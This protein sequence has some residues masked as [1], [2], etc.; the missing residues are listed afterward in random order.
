M[1]EQEALNL[2]GDVIARMGGQGDLREVAIDVL[3]IEQSYQRDIVSDHADKIARNWNPLALGVLIASLRADGKLWLIDGQHRAIAARLNGVATLMVQ[4]F[5]GLTL[6][7]EAA[8]RLLFNRRMTDK[9]NER[10]RA[11][12]IAGNQESIEIQRICSEFDTRVNL[13]PDVKR[14]INAVSAVE[15]LYRRDN[16]M[17]LTRVFEFIRET[18]GEVHGDKA[19]VALLKGV[20][21][22]LDKHSGKFDRARM[23]ERL[24]LE[25]VASI[26]RKAAN[27]RV[28]HGGPMHQNAYRAM[29]EIYNE[30]LTESNRLEWRTGGWSSK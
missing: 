9:P 13:S 28:V 8:L 10:F 26:M 1:S 24:R 21:Q 5:Q 4:V 3:E 19:T 12:L 30:R 16:G 11:Q 14:G 27:H 20:G 7:E 2:A 18:F 17:L 23:V 22:L 6:A 29:I 15:S 25:G